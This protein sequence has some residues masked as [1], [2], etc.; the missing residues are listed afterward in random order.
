MAR[1][2]SRK[3]KSIYIGEGEAPSHGAWAGHRSE[4]E[5]PS[6]GTILSSQ[7][8]SSGPGFLHIVCLPS[9]QQRNHDGASNSDYTLSFGHPGHVIF[10]SLRVLLHPGPPRRS[11]PPG[12]SSSCRACCSCSACRSCRARRG[13]RPRS[14]GRVRPSG[15]WR[16]SRPVG[17]RA[18]RSTSPSGRRS[19][20]RC[21]QNGRP[22][23]AGANLPRTECGSGRSPA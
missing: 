22:G 2:D 7:Q 18:T 20:P 8:H 23:V 5:A 15:R 6:R 9:R 12:A 10:V 19:S 14:G 3:L 17:T 13:G 1:S 11:A 16:A 21:G 4:D